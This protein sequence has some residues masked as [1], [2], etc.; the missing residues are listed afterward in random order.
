[1]QQQW[2]NSRHCKHSNGQVASFVNEHGLGL[3]ANEV[4]IRS[5]RFDTQH[6][7]DALWIE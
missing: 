3:I 2:N 4:S 7:Q 6:V 5:R 1:M